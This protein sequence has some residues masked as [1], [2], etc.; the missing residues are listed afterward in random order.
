MSQLQ[1]IIIIKY[2]DFSCDYVYQLS[3]VSQ[4][5]NFS[6]SLWQ[7]GF[8]STTYAEEFSPT[9]VFPGCKIHYLLPLCNHAKTRRPIA[10]V[11]FH[12]GLHVMV[13][14]AREFYYYHTLHL[15]P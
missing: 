4:H 14:Q 5:I 6:L 7:A 12:S 13:Y 3:T 10:L 11:H 2:T 8:N 15:W 1:F 9:C